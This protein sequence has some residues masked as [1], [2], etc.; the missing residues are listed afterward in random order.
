MTTPTEV[1]DLALQYTNPEDAPVEPIKIDPRETISVDQVLDVIQRVRE[2]T[3]HSTDRATESI[4]E[5]TAHALVEAA[6]ETL[7]TTR[8]AAALGVLQFKQPQ[9]FTRTD[10]D[11]ELSEV[12]IRMRDYY[13]VIEGAHAFISEESISD[14]SRG[15]F[16]E[17]LAIEMKMLED[18]LESP[19]DY[20]AA[21]I[22]QAIAIL[23][24]IRDYYTKRTDVRKSEQDRERPKYGH[25]TQKHQAHGHKKD[26]NIKGKGTY[27]DAALAE[28][29]QEEESYEN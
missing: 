26:K 27:K 28:L 7:E 20:D 9:G 22:G 10:L 16:L 24:N 4:T 15:Q 8:M 1:K 11:R 21:Q 23:S 12:D 13:L 18:T 17:F 25:T 3:A 6:H 14:H 2:T 29:A 19:T 5:A